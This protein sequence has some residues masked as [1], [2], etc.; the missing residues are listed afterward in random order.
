M[1]LILVSGR[2]KHIIH[3][4]NFINRMENQWHHSNT[5]LPQSLLQNG[6]L[7]TAQCQRPRDQTTRSRSGTWPQ[8]KTVQKPIQLRER[9]SP[10]CPLSCCL[11]TRDRQTLRSYTGILSSR[12]SSS[13]P[14]TVDSMCLGRSVCETWTTAA[15]REG[16]VF[17]SFPSTVDLYDQSSV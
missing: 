1:F 3:C 16:T 13:A 10:V 6:T 8:K 5:T 2:S 4:L 14:P 7:M 15:E 9:K 12:G 11:F 17:K